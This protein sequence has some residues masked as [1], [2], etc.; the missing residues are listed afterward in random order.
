LYFD[1]T[2]NFYFLA[3]LRFE[4]RAWSLIYHS[5][6]DLILLLLVC[7]QVG[8]HAS[9]QT[10][11]PLWPSYLSF[12]SSWNYRHVLW[13]MVSVTFARAGFTFQSFCLCLPSSWD[14]QCVRPCPHCNDF[15]KSFT[16]HYPMM[17]REI[18]IFGTLKVE[19]IIIEVKI[20]YKYSCVMA[21]MQTT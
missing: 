15:Y 3:K 8:S 10:I 16:K 12:L 4:L 7:F 18:S 21:T 9:T 19:Y 17:R 11:L 6:C 5:S 20:T 2:R 1:F 14:Y 13:D